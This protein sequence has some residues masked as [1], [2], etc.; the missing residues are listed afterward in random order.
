M[1]HNLG[2]PVFDGR[3]FD[4]TAGLDLVASPGPLGGPRFVM[5]HLDNVSL[6][7]GARLTVNVG[8]GTDEFTA[9]SGTDFWSRPVD[10]SISPIAIR[11]VGGTG[12]ARLREYGSG[13]ATVTGSPGAPCGSQTNPDVF[14]HRSP[15]VEP[16]YET[17]LQW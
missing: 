10:G 3:T 14:L 4:E 15:Y 2:R 8:Y 12:S 9:G 13:E 7:G 1:S 17:R 11:I 6:H 16:T 5:L